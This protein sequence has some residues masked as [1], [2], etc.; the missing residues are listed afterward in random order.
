MSSAHIGLNALLLTLESSYRGAGINTYI[1]NLLRQLARLASGHRYSVFLSER[2]FVEPRLRLYYSGWQT[3]RPAV[4]ILWEQLVLP[5]ALRRAGVD[6]LHAMA[7]VAPLYE[8]CPF[9][10]TVYDLSFLHYP[11]LFRPLNRHYLR[12]FGRRSARRA[13]RVLTIS[14]STRQD[15]VRAWNVP[16][17]RIDVTYCGVDPAF[18]PLS[19]EELDA[20]RH[21]RGL[22]EHFV[23]FLGTLEPRKNLDTLLEAYALWCQAQPSAPALVIAGAK[24]WYFQ[25]VFAS[26]ERLELSQRV[27]FAGYVPIAELPAWYGAADLFVYPSQYE[28]FGLPVLEAMACG[29]PV[30]TSDRSSL[31][32]VVGE[33][34]CLVPPDDASQLAKSLRQVWNDGDLR[35]AMRESGLARAAQFSWEQTARQTIACYERALGE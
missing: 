8:A 23:L 5:L 12:L 26:V 22:P 7:F 27:H 14:E 18:R 16:P 34:G 11:Q 19:A 10:L 35:Q 1:Y 4:R 29:T 32:E 9:V 15:V 31:P 17:E 24:G 2:R 33:A 6:L 30:I 3:R 13:R 20:F 28:G 21:Q 25:H